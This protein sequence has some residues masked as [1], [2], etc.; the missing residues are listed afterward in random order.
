MNAELIKL[1]FDLGDTHVQR[2][3]FPQTLRVHLSDLIWL[4]RNFVH[5]EGGCDASKQCKWVPENSTMEYA[6]HFRPWIFDREVEEK[7]H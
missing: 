4:K 3:V 7:S 1:L 5:N 2:E 6:W